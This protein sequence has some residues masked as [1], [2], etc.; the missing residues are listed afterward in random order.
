MCSLIDK[1]Y[2]LS[3]YKWFKSYTYKRKRLLNFIRKI[4]FVGRLGPWRNRVMKYLIRHSPNPVLSTNE[5]TLFPD[6][7][8]EMIANAIKTSG[9]Y[10][11]IYLPEE[12]V[13]N[14]IENYEEKNVRKYNNPHKDW[15]VVEAI[16]LDPKL[17]EVA[18]RY[19]KVE[20]ILYSTSIY[21]SL[22]VEDSQN[23]PQLNKREFHFD[24]GDFK[25]LSLFIYLTDVDFESGPHVLIENT[26]NKTFK[27]LLSP[28]INFEQ[29]VKK[30]KAR[31]K[32][33]TGK[34]GTMFFEDLRSY[35]QRS[36]GKKTR[37][38]LTVNYTFHRQPPI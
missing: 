5:T 4:R 38:V 23:L 30:Y 35:H 31:I 37:L 16:A 26:H 18:R 12:Y 20:P 9:Y 10:S 21:R 3:T 19:L 15:Q 24:V 28:T 36:F 27:Q 33:I 17:V 22:P 7:S 25:D 13:N 34:K 11:G 32:T 1:Y 29:A 14:I 2:F 8:A 6:L